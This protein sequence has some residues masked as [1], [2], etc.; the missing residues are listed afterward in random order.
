MGKRCSQ[1]P[2]ASAP[3]GFGV[4]RLPPKPPPVTSAAGLLWKSGEGSPTQPASACQTA[5]LRGSR[6]TCRATLPAPHPPM[7]PCT[8]CAPS[9][10]TRF[11]PGEPAPCRPCSS[12]QGPPGVFP[13]GSSAVTA[14][15]AW[16]KPQMFADWCPLD[17]FI[18]FWDSLNV[19]RVQGCIHFW[20][21]SS[22]CWVVPR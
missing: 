18:S 10:L 4:L 11:V 12:P 20:S 16:A 2:Q 5:F 19:S 6:V 22:S 3:G 13:S 21:V 7:L 15:R 9:A 14:S 1:H 17:H 8:A